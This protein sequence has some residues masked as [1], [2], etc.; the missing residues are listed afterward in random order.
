M[1]HP[2]HPGCRGERMTRPTDWTPLGYYNDPIPGDP[3]AVQTAATD[4]TSVAETITRAATNLRGLSGCEGM[5]SEAVSALAEQADD[6]AER[7][8]RAQKRYAGVG[9]ALADYVTPL[10]EAQATSLQALM[11][12]N[13]A[14]QAQLD[15]TTD[16]ARYED[17]LFDPGLT[18]EDRRDYER[19]QDDAISDGAGAAT[20]LAAA[21]VLLQSAI[22]Q[23][24]VAASIAAEAISEVENS[25][26][27]NDTFWDNV[28]QF[29]DQHSELID[30]LILA[31]GILAAALVVVALFIPIAGWVI[32]AAV[33]AVTTA[34][35]L[36]AAAQT[37]TGHKSLT[38]GIIEVAFA[39][40]PFALGKV[41]GKLIGRQVSAVR[42]ATA[43]AAATA[44]MKSKAGQ[45][46]SGYTRGVAK[47]EIDQIA[48]ST[49]PRL[50]APPVVESRSVPR[51]L[52]EWRAMSSLE[53]KSGLVSDKVIAA[54]Q[55]GKMWTLGGVWAV[56]E[57]G[58]P[59]GEGVVKGVAEPSY[60]K[61][62]TVRDENW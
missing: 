48:A 56:S 35:V 57:F 11:N 45:G 36:N 54:S 31:A 24:N 34:T 6:V 62:F 9:L 44:L 19:K 12:A 25:G 23:R 15:A 51:A 37:A 30:N 7:I 33:I 55:P 13:T 50:L 39:L 26:K 53:L 61:K 59:V 21:V 16:Q 40:V 17:R 18:T 4:Y 43:D 27:L 52:A 60:L 38:E 1:H 10:S 22:D 49:A 46:I 14:C 47:A 28:D 3:S 41:A 5:V 42:A 58:A 32:A 29:F 20:M 2:G 8:E